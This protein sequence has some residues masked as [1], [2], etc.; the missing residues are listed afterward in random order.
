MLRPPEAVPAMKRQGGF[1]G[2]HNQSKLF[3][4]RWIILE[5]T[6]YTDTRLFPTHP[7]TPVPP[8]A[9]AA[10]GFR[11]P[12][13]TIYDMLTAPFPTITHVY[14]H[15]KRHE[16]FHIKQSPRR[17]SPEEDQ[18]AGRTQAI[19]G[20]TPRTSPQA[21]SGPQLAQERRS[22]THTS[23]ANPFRA[24]P[25]VVIA[26]PRSNKCTLVRLPTFHTISKDLGVSY[27][28]ATNPHLLI[29]CI[30]LGSNENQNNLVFRHFFL[31]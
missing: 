29:T 2:S 14:H 23:L 31:A 15:T 11:R 12:R 19:A 27:P 20:I 18:P 7:Y 10:S 6:L 25:E 24:W 21:I 13:P 1:L 9:I 26:S 30:Y 5:V 22:T 8:T 3:S 4:K 28:F 16:L 17:E